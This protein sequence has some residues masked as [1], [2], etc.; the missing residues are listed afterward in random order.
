MSSE[1]HLKSSDGHLR[2]ILGSFEGCL[3]VIWG[4]S[5]GKLK[6]ISRSYEAHLGSS[7][8][9]LRVII[10]SCCSLML[11]HLTFILDHGGGAFWIYFDES[12]SCCDHSGIILVS[13]GYDA[14]IKKLR[15]NSTKVKIEFFSIYI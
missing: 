7:E 11:D 12:V 2:I 5:E 9:H 3:T 4:S 1:Y 14:G 13:F 15:C 8:D 10:S 6:V